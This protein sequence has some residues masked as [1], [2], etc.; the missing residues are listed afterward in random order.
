MI[1]HLD[2]EALTA[3]LVGGDE[4]R[5]LEHLET[6]AYCRKEAVDLRQRLQSLSDAIHDAGEARG[7]ER[8]WSAPAATGRKVFA[9]A[10]LT[11]TAR[12]ALA[13]CV[14]A[15][16]LLIHSPRPTGPAD[17]GDASDNALLEKIQADLNRRAPRALA[18]AESLLAQ[19]TVTENSNTELQGGKQ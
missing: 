16:A 10:I 9:G 7:I 6:C 15:T 1:A 14:L 13:A 5:V 11:W 12:A 17:S 19:M 3:W 18:P 2:D 4:L 8:V